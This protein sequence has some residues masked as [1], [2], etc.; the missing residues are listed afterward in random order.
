MDL[1]DCDIAV[2]ADESV[3]GD[4]LEEFRSGLAAG[5]IRVFF[6]N[7][8]S[9]AYATAEWWAVPTLIL[10]FVSRKFFDAFMAEAGKDAYRFCREQFV[11]LI[12]RTTGPEAD[13]HTQVVVSDHASKKLPPE[14]PPFVSVYALSLRGERVRFVFTQDLLPQS[15]EMAVEAMFDLLAQHYESVPHDALTAL[16][17][18]AR[19]RWGV[20]H[21]RFDQ[22]SSAWTPALREQPSD[23]TT[24]SSPRLS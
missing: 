12:R 22:Q 15:I 23:T 21:L 10:L 3:S 13:V 11:R 24:Q 6:E 4:L 2:S 14:A 1:Q 7:R 20:I 17:T 9:S 8:E 18:G 19:P 16:L 5:N